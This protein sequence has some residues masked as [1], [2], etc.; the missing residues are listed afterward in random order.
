KKEAEKKEA[1]AKDADKSGAD[2][3]ETATKTAETKK[4]EKK[5]EKKEEKKLKEQEKD[6]QEIAIDLQIPRKTPKGTIVLRGA[7]VVTMKTGKEDEVMKN[8]DI[9]VENNRSKSVG[10]K[11]SV[12]AGAKVFDVS[13][14]TISPGFID[15]HAHW[16]EIRRGILD[17]QN[18]SFL[19][20]LA[21]GVTAGRD[22]QTGTNDMFAYQD[23]VDTGEMIGPRAYSTGPGVFADTDF[24]AL[25]DVKN[26]VSKYKEYYRTHSLKSYMIGNRKQREWMV[27]AC[28]SEKVMPTTEGGLDTMMDLTHVMDGMSGNEHSLPILP[29]YNDVVQLMA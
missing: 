12:P 7:T 27:M 24:Q 25:D 6:V 15:T 21:F 23:L 8:A 5:D 10:A 3:K 16:T 9:V 13:G 26:V 22:P 18:W 4:D 14:K 11:G 1:E 29:L 19:A 28:E 2:K 17:T 20:N